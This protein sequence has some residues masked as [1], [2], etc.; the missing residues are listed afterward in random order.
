[1][2]YKFT[3]IILFCFFQFMCYAQHLTY[4]DIVRISRIS[5]ISEISDFVA[6]K[7]YVYAG[8]NEKDSIAEVFWTRNC[9]V[10]I[11]SGNFE[12]SNGQSRSLLFLKITKRF[13]EYHYEL[14]S[15]SAYKALIASL[16]S[17][18][19]KLQKE[20]IFDGCISSTYKR[21]RSGKID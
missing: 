12:W 3:L 13:I 10:N 7:G 1:M 18:G 11:N 2:K 6:S 15:R 5:R 20:T 9:S 21:N 17:N 8:T 16:K 14:P 19:F 4:G